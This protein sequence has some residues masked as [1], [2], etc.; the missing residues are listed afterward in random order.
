M[1][2]NIIFVCVFGLTFLLMNGAATKVYS[3]KAVVLATEAEFLMPSFVEIAGSGMST[4][5]PLTPT[6]TTPPNCPNDKEDYSNL[7]CCQEC[8]ETKGKLRSN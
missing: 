8:Y 6:P 5:H 7:M 4:D 3:S 2:Y 1:S